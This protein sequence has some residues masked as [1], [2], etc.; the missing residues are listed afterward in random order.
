M[1]PLL[2]MCAA[3]NLGIISSSAVYACICHTGHSLL[4]ARILLYPVQTRTH[5][6]DLDSIVGTYAVRRSFSR[7]VRLRRWL[8]ASF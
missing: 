2:R 4:P 1:A 8:H 6:S 3:I 5:L 7:T